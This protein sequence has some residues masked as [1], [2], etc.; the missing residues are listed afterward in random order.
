MI[1]LAVIPLV[2]L[3]AVPPSLL[4]HYQQKSQE[5][6]TI[7]V[8][9]VVAYRLRH[10]RLAIKARA[11]LLSPKHTRHRLHRGNRIVI[12]YTTYRHWPTGMLGGPAI[13]VIQKGQVY[14]AYLKRRRHSR[15]YTPAAGSRSFIQIR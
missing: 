6:V 12:R 11:R 8:E 10:N 7:K 3:G 14:R 9:R 13:P 4:K 5:I 2:A 1:A 15:S